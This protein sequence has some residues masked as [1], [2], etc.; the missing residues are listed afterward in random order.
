M[1]ALVHAVRSVYVLVSLQHKFWMTGSKEGRLLSS[2]GKI[3][4][5]NLLQ[6]FHKLGAVL[7]ITYRYGLPL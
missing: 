5:C 6:I 3:V 2:I 1:A 4:D 7:W